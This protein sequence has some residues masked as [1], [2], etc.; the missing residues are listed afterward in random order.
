MGG[1]IL[2]VGGTGPTGIPLVRGLVERGHD[3]TILHRGRHESPETPPEVRHLHADPYD[4]AALRE[5]ADGPAYDTVIAMYGRLRRIAAAWAGRTGRFLSVGGVP[6]YRGWMNPELAGPGGLPVPVGED[7]PLVRTPEEDAKGH[8]IVCTEEAVFAHHPT[9][10][11]VRYPYVYGPHQLAPREWCV[12]RRVLDGR[13]RI[14]VADGGLTLHHHGYTEN[15]AHALLLAVDH[16]EASAGR[17]YNAADDEVLTVRQVIATVAAALGHT[18][19]VVSLPYELAVPAR[20]ML[21]QPAAEHRVLDLTRIRADLGYRDLVAPREALARTARWLA[22]HPPAPGGTEEQVL[23]DP[24]D[25]PAEDRL[26]DAW[27]ALPRLTTDFAVQPGF[28]LA[29]SGPG[30]RPRGN[31]EFTA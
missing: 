17:I 15:L 16:P 3:V 22:A 19:E 8:R 23:T 4:E 14:V 24:F 5:A 28:G 18:F 1:R 26:M 2:V 11:H 31:P 7:A 12:V 29:Y 25:Y 20:P 27:A 21:M 6:A 10:T 30:G 9:A 13:R